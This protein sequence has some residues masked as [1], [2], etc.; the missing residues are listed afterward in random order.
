[1]SIPITFTPLT[2]GG[3][4]S[5]EVE[6][7]DDPSPGSVGDKEMRGTLSFT[8]AEWDFL[9]GVLEVGSEIDE[10]QEEELGYRLI[11]G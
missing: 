10:E 5:V 6:V 2:L 8:Q 7:G 3:R 9:L 11:I 4:V 1:M